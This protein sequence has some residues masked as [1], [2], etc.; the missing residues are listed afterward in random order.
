MREAVLQ[1]QGNRIFN[2]HLATRICEILTKP[3]DF[4]AY[5]GYCMGQLRFAHIC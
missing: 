5:V 4:D 2:C 3:F 1:W